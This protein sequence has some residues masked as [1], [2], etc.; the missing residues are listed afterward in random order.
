MTTGILKCE[1]IN[2]VL[3]IDCVMAPAGAKV[4]I[5]EDHGSVYEVAYYDGQSPSRTFYVRAD[6]V[7]LN[8]D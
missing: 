2:T 8:D 1:V 7:R 4:T 3:D 6:Q 5:I